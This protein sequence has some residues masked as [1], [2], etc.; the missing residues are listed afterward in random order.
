MVDGSNH[1]IS[2]GYNGAPSG[3]S[4]CSENGYCLKDRMGVES[5][6]DRQCKAV[7]AEANA[8][9][10]AARHGVSTDGATCYCTTAPCTGC[11]KMLINAGVVRVVYIEGYPDDLGRAMM[12]NQGIPV[13]S[14]TALDIQVP[15]MIN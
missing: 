1:I 15:E 8:I 4:H 14:S 3:V 10:Q 11:S 5:G 13:E 2:T 7:H 6:I 12:T 9:I